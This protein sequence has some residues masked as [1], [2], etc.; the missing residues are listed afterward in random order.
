MPRKE[1]QYLGLACW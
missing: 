1:A